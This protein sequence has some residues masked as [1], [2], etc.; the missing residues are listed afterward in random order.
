VPAQ[1]LLVTGP[2]MAAVYPRL[3]SF[4]TVGSAPLTAAVAGA[5]SFLLLPLALGGAAVSDQLVSLLYGGKFERSATILA[6]AMSLPAIGAFNSVVGQ[7]LAA[8]G[9]Q[10]TVMRVALG[11]AAFNVGLNVVLLPTVGIVG[12]AVAVAAS[13]ALTAVAFMYA[14]RRLSGTAARAF[15]PNL[16][17]AAVAA[18][19]VLAARALWSTPLGV[20][21]A[22]G[23]AVY[24]GLSV[25]LPTAGGR[26]VAE[27]LLTMLR[28]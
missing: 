26:R 5:L 21:I 13:E 11:T 14:D 4:G 1:L 3:S 22:L 15:A 10:T 23:A 28:R 9:R 2:V 7:A 16:A 25:A 18:G 8:R 20:N 6:I 12:A 19:A 27:A 24:L 17:H